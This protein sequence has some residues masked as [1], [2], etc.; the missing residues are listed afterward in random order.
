MTGAGPGGGAGDARCGHCG[1]VLSLEDL[2]QPA[3]RYCG[4]IHAHVARAAE[5]VAIVHGI[6]GGVIVPP[7]R[8]AQGPS[9]ILPGVVM[10]GAPPSPPMM[11]GPVPIFDA[12]AGAVAAQKKMIKIGIIIAVSAVLFF[13]ALGLG[14]VALLWGLK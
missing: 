13:T 12:H 11:G 3:C 8:G 6:M 9:P 1:G 5:K 2:S 14:A 4:S 7:P 10:P